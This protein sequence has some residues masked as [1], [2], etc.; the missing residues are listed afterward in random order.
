MFKQ[1][2][3]CMFNNEYYTTIKLQILRGVERTTS[4][5]IMNVPD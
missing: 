4:R 1:A 2:V 3:L 5:Y